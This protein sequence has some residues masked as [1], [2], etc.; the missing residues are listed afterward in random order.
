MGNTP[1]IAPPT[2]F[3]FL[4]LSSTSRH[5]RSSRFSPTS[6]S[7][8]V[9]LSVVEFFF[10]KKIYETVLYPC[11]FWWC[12]YRMI[13]VCVKV[14][15]SRNEHKIRRETP[16]TKS[17]ESAPFSDFQYI[18]YSGLHSI[19]TI[20]SYGP[21][22]CRHHMISLHPIGPFDKYNFSTIGSWNRMIALREWLRAGWRLPPKNK[23]WLIFRL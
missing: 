20:T 11:L 6:D 18:L 21:V 16:E 2:A 13:C 22:V 3:H 14:S 4:P 1:I 9:K 15:T 19:R 5:R 17:Q 7:L 10:F 8:A 12:F 23:V